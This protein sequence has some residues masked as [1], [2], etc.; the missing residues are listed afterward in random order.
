LRTGEGRHA[1]ARQD[2]AVFLLLDYSNFQAPTGSNYILI[3]PY[4]MIVMH[5]LPSPRDRKRAGASGV[6]G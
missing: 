5:P 4:W 3:L 6:M 2:L 1:G